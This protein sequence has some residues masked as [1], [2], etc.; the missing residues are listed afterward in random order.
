M[1]L[2]ALSSNTVGFD[3]YHHAYSVS[4]FSALN[5]NLGNSLLGLQFP[6]YLYFPYVLVYVTEI[7]D[8]PF[9]FIISMFYGFLFSALYRIE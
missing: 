5:K 6:R 3:L 4:S 2:V 1:S 7:L 9:A 8:I